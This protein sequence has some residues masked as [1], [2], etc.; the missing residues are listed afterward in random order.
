MILFLL[1]VEPLLLC[2]KEV[3][4][5]VSLATRQVREAQFPEVVC[6]L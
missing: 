1:Y 3:T 5:G 4:K 2:M 6:M